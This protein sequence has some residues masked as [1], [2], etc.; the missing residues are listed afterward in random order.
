MKKLK[1]FRNLALI[2]S[3]LAILFGGSQQTLATSDVTEAIGINDLLG[4]WQSSDGTQLLAIAECISTEAYYQI[5]DNG[6]IFD[7]GKI[8]VSKGALRFSSDSFDKPDVLAPFTYSADGL[9][10]TIQEPAASTLG[11]TAPLNRRDPGT[12]T[13]VSLN[14]LL[15]A[16]QSGDKTQVLA[17]AKWIS[18]EAY[19]QIWRNGSV[20]DTGKIS[21]SR[22]VL[23]FDREAYDKPDILA[24]FSYLTDVQQLTILEPAASQL[25]LTDP[26]RPPDKW[27]DKGKSQELSWRNLDLEDLTI[28]C[29]AVHPQDANVIYA[30]TDFGV[31]K[32]AD[33]G[34]RW[35]RV[36]HE[37]GV[38]GLAIDPNRPNVVYAG[39]EEGLYRTVDAGAHWRCITPAAEVLHAAVKPHYITALALAPSAPRVLYVAGLDVQESISYVFRSVDAGGTWQLLQSVPWAVTLLVADPIDSDIVYCAVWDDL[40][41]AGEIDKSADGGLTWRTLTLT[42]SPVSCLAIDPSD[43][44]IIYAGLYGAGVYKSLDGG[45][46]WKL[47]DLEDSEVTSLLVSPGN[48][49]VIFVATDGNGVYRSSDGGEKYAE[50]NEGLSNLSVLCLASGSNGRLYAGT[51]GGG[52]FTLSW[53]IAVRLPD[54]QLSSTFIEFEDVELDSSA[55]QNLRISNVGTGT[56]EVTDISSDSPQFTVSPTSFQ[57]SPGGSQVVTVTFAPRSPGLKTATISIKSNDPDQAVV[58]VSLKGI[59]A[60]PD[61]RLSATSHSFGDVRVGENAL[62]TLKIYNTGRATLQLKA[63]MSDSRAFTLPGL[64]FPQGIAASDSLACRVVFSPDST[65]QFKGTLVIVSNDPDERVLKVALTGRGVA[66]RISLSALSHDF[67]N[68]SVDSLSTWILT[69]SN[70]GNAPLSVSEIKSS[71]L[72][73]FPLPR[74][75]NVEPDSSRKVAVGFRPKSPGSKSAVL[76]IVSNDPDKSVLKVTLTG[77]GAVP[78]IR[79]SETSYDFGNVALDS[80]AVWIF[81]ISNLGN[82]PLSGT[83]VSDNPEF[84]VT[85][86]VF[87]VPAGDSIQVEITFTPDSEGSKSAVLIIKSNDPERPHL[88][89]A[90]SGFSMFPNQPPSVSVLPLEGEQSGDI[91]VTYTLQDTEADTLSILCSYSTDEGTTWHSASVQGKTEGITAAEYSGTVVWKS[92]DDLSGVD[93]PGVKFRITPQDAQSGSSDQISF[94]LDNNKPPAAELAE[95]TGERARDVTISY[96]LSDPE[97]DSLDISCEY[98]QDGGESW[99]AAS[100]T[101]STAG[102]GPHRYS[103][104]II[105][106][107]FED[108]GYGRFQDV[109]FRVTPKDNDQGTTGVTAAFQVRN[110]AGDY[111][112]DLDVDFDDLTVFLT[113]WE[114]NDLTKEIGPAHGT[115]PDLLPQPDG[116]LDFEDLAVF[117][118]MWNWSAQPAVEKLA[119]PMP[120]EGR[121][122][123]VK[124]GSEGPEVHLEART[125]GV[126]DLLAAQLLIQ[127][128]PQILRCE[129]VEPGDIFGSNSLFLKKID[130]KKGTVLVNTGRLGGKSLK[131]GILAKLQF[132]RLSKASGEIVT[133]YDL[134]GAGGKRLDV[135]R[136]AFGMDVESEAFK[137]LQNW[138]NPFNS[139]TVIT[140]ILPEASVVSLKVF[141]TLGQQVRVLAHRAQGPGRFS[142]KWDG[143]D[144]ARRPVASG[145][146]ICRMSTQ[147]ISTGDVGFTTDIR[148]IL[149][150]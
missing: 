25:G 45:I 88:E 140:Y 102:I 80:S 111:D 66:P 150:R 44:D 40:Q 51:D 142:V 147:S 31:F 134:R 13:D 54:I 58:T 84:G 27:V 132:R 91:T 75:F 94:H 123:K 17:I 24:P 78:E 93:L 43:S 130:T 103:G 83:I 60:A 121:A 96:Q 81:A 101:G 145:V 136:V 120:T 63:I 68:V 143:R 122:V 71:S 57:L 50:I 108:L 8:S 21:V 48:A 124:V 37:K 11:L 7:T 23:R 131:N 12:T 55:T 98:S 99:S 110:L 2:C 95:I 65:L 67:G 104:Q 38:T 135:G 113:A 100:V 109:R 117:I 35:D 144:E 28:Y 69:V 139:G 30:G 76:T 74:S 47:L 92:S 106:H 22:G 85:P 5:W 29:L 141:N 6:A 53:P 119:R 105:W 14:N 18:T 32:T 56:L 70:I 133:I 15:D 89:V 10:L 61:I 79:L 34:S 126:S 115:V 26:L 107:S 73:F 19:Y 9:S 127:Y 137:L 128:D 116:L 148:M 125:D 16:W 129:G 146:Y 90:L 41:G 59:G 46:N 149:L 3:L 4:V 138:P 118:L 86:D 97:A 36:S 82:A 39:T 72:E 64:T 52:V 33:G 114:Q 112:G 42:T 77:T 20:F 87:T 49:E 62:W 1:N